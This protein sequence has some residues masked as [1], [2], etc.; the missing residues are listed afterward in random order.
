MMLTVSRYVRARREALGLSQADLAR[1]AEMTRANVAALETRE[2]QQPR[3]AL[4]GRLARALD[5]NPV[6]LL[7]LGGY[8]DGDWVDRLLIAPLV[9]GAER[10]AHR[11]LWQSAV[12]GQYLGHYRLERHCSAAECA[13]GT[14]SLLNLETASEA[15]WVMVE[16]GK[17]P[18]SWL[19]TRRTDT[20]L[21]QAPGVV[22]W[23]LTQSL[24]A[25]LT[26]L[27]HLLG[28]LRPK[29]AEAAGVDLTPY[30]VALRG[31]WRTEPP[32][33]DADSYA[34]EF[35]AM[36]S[37]GAGEGPTARQTAD[38]RWEISII[39]PTDTPPATVGEVLALLS[40]VVRSTDEPRT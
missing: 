5:V 19:G 36:G 11:E 2:H 24:S 32:W 38:G 16:S 29:I 25:D 17:V 6:V 1:A 31:A 34:R 18:G 30:D 26:G 3:P 39:L 10:I 8:L 4:C 7:A 33:I 23:A 14:A 22:L 37:A 35:S 13:M 20:A 21:I 12:A 40:R 15:D 9:S 28:R 27:A